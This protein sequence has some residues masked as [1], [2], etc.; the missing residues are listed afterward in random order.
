MKE[1]KQ[2]HEEKDGLT[3][4]YREIKLDFGKCDSKQ[5]LKLSELLSLCADTAVEDYF[6]FL[7]SG[8]SD[9]PVELLKLA[10]VDL[11]KQTAFDAACIHLDG[12]KETSGGSPL[13]KN[14]SGISDDAVND[15]A[16]KA[17]QA[18]LDRMSGK[19]K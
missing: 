11:T 10:G 2:W 19:A 15:E 17:H 3:P 7:S 1:F 12:L 6:K 16:E 9:S 18:M 5:H 13:A 8:G 4:F 14:F